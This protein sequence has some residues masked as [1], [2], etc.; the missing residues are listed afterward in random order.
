MKVVQENDRLKEYVRKI[1]D[2]NKSCK[3]QMEDLVQAMSA[4]MKKYKQQYEEKVRIFEAKVK[5]L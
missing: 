2:E 4:K 5:F 1:K 3:I